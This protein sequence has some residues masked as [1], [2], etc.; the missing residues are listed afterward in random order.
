M[1]LR[2][3][4]AI[5]TG[6]N[7]GI[8]K[9]IALALADQGANIVID[10]VA[11]P[12][13][14]EELEKRLAALGSRS[15]GVEAD[16]SRVSDL[17]KLVSAAVGAFGR[18]DIMV[19][20]A[21]IETR[22]SVLDSTEDQYDKLMAINLKS[23]FF[24]TQIAARQM[25]KQGGGG[26]I[27]NIT[28]VHED[29]PMPGNAPYCLSKGGMR[30][31]TRT[32]GVELAPHNILV[33]GVGPGAVATPINLVTMKDPA[34]MHKLDTA[35]PIG[36]MAKPDEIGSVVAFLAG[37][38]ASYVTATTIFADGGLMHQSPGL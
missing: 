37:D 10:Y 30:M 14:T 17:H 33:V 27:I 13:A 4:V 34:L 1:A 24:G 18:L 22:T 25:I 7:S 36:R 21:G 23:A 20:N 31:L 15:I 5:V 12:N 11:H 32:A 38:G 6:G 16:V 35:I 2:Q 29:W 9:A 19:N 26:R 3:K 28:S 8:G